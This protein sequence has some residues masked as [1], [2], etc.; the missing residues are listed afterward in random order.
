[1][2]NHFKFP[3]FGWPFST[4]MVHL[5]GSSM[6]VDQTHLLALLTKNPEDEAIEIVNGVITAT[7]SMKIAQNYV[8]IASRDT[9]N[10]CLVVSDVMTHQRTF[11]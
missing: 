3:K 10:T 2:E 9:K 4:G 11:I 7:S 8:A 5:K 1:M 6:P